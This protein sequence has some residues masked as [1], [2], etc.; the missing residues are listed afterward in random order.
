MKKRSVI[1][2][3]N[4]ILSWGTPGELKEYELWEE[5]VRD[6]GYRPSSVREKKQYLYWKEVFE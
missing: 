1:F 6:R 5:R 3:V 4:K 2:D